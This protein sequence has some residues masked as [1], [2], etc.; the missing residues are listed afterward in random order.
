[1][2]QLFSYRYMLFIKIIDQRQ[3]TDFNPCG[4]PCVEQKF[5][6]TVQQTGERVEGDRIIVA[7]PSQREKKNT[8]D[9]RILQNN[10]NHESHNNRVFVW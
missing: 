9:G 4:R 5:S 3:V 10:N 1:M 7:V 2:L 6:H 8:S